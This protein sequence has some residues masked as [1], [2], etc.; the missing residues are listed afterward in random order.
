MIQLLFHQAYTIRIPTVCKRDI[1]RVF[2]AIILRNA[3]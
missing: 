1:L 3:A 2:D